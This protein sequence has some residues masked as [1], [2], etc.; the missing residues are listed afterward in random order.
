M[1]ITPFLLFQDTLSATDAFESRPL[2]IAFPSKSNICNVIL[3]GVPALT[4]FG[5][6]EEY[7]KVHPG[8]VITIIK[9]T[10]TAIHI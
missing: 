9:T 5:K 4:S 6:C 8:S 10:T 7:F 1:N 2:Y 3:N